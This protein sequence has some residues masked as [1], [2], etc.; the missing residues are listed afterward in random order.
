MSNIARDKG[1]PK[2]A[3]AIRVCGIIG[4]FLSLMS[5]PNFILFVITIAKRDLH[6]IEFNE[7]IHSNKSRKVDLFL[8]YFLGWCGAHRFYEKKIVSGVFYALTFG[9]LGFGWII[10]FYKNLA[11]TT[12]KN[13]KL[14]VLWNSP[15]ERV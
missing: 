2:L 6:P 14:I 15:I 10:D 11:A 3:T 13:K 4:I 5:I 7:Q 9:F 1:Y 12:E 8:T